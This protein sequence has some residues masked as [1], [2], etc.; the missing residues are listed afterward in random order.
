MWANVMFSRLPAL[1]A[2][3]GPEGCFF[4]WAGN[5]EGLTELSTGLGGELPLGAWRGGLIRSCNRSYSPGRLGH[6][7]Q[8]GVP[9]GQWRS[10]GALGTLAPGE[11]T[12]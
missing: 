1:R 12:K 11:D 6:S 8:S 9:S 10:T 5:A 4:P 2:S 7:F 3:D